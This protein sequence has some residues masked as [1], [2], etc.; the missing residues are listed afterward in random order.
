MLGTQL[1]LQLDAPS[2]MPVATPESTTKSKPDISIA[3]G[4]KA[5][6]RDILAAIRTLKAIEQRTTAGNVRGKANACPLRRFR[7]GRPLDFS[8]PG[9]RPV[10]GRR[11][12]SVWAKS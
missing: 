12:A 5:K 10:Q 1:S 2:F 11:L 7:S 9:H 3:S 8:R 4:E 6:A